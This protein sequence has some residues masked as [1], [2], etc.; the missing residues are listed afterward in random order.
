MSADEDSRTILY[1]NAV[2]KARTESAG[3]QVE[4]KMHADNFCDG[5][6][7]NCRSASVINNGVTESIRY[8]PGIVRSGEMSSRNVSTPLN[9]SSK[10]TFYAANQDTANYL[11]PTKQSPLWFLAYYSGTGQPQLGSIQ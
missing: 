8:V 6:G 7:N 4:G 2:W 1:N 9:I 11:C 10:V 5:D 3:F